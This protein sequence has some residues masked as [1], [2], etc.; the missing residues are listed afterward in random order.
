M[1]F[2]AATQVR[3]T[4]WPI[5]VGAEGIAA[6]QFARCGFDVL[7]Q[8]GRDKPWYDLVVTRAGSLLKV[9]VKASDDSEWRLTSGYSRSDQATGGM[10]FDI[11]NAIDRWMASHGSR[12]VCCL[13]Q[14]NR[15]AIDE[16][17][18]IYLALPAEVAQAM[19]ETADHIGRCVVCESY[20]WTRPDGSSD[21]ET[22]PS[23]WRFSP[24]RVEELLAHHTGRLATPFGAGKKPAAPSLVPHIVLH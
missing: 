9:S 2:L 1:A 14:F 16:M 17:P 13:V 12:T 18:R 15:V 6:A 5:T 24:Q 4:S 19:R 11:H 8:A 7:V 23:S 10:P 21:I 20:E 22:L 3:S